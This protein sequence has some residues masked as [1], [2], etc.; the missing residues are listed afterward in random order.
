MVKTV[1][2][3]DICSTLIAKYLTIPLCTYEY[4]YQVFSGAALVPKVEF[5]IQT[6]EINGA[7]EGGC[8]CGQYVYY[9]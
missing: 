6:W 5:I 4:V 7:N 1:K 9:Y 2:Q 3:D 8:L